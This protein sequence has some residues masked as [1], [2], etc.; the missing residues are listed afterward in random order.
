MAAHANKNSPMEP[1]SPE[2][3]GC[4]HISILLASTKCSNGLEAEQA[5]GLAA[6]GRHK[7]LGAAPLGLFVE[8]LLHFQTSGYFFRRYLIKLDDI[9]S[10]FAQSS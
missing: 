1:E 6:F 9:L 4:C 2:P 8:A 7:G 3:R 10:S 5:E